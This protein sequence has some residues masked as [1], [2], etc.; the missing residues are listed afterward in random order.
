VTWYKEENTFLASQ[1]FEMIN[2]FEQGSKFNNDLRNEYDLLKRK[3]GNSE[4]KFQSLLEDYERAARW[5]TIHKDTVEDYKNCINTFGLEYILDLS[6]QRGN[7]L[8]TKAVL[9][10][11]EAKGTWKRLTLRL[12][13]KTCRVKSKNPIS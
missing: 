7:I 11:K 10:M 2:K 1:I 12:E 13:T 6:D 5:I 4:S 9:T 8:S 3:L